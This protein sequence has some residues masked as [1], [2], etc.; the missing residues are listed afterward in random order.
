WDDPNYG[1]D[2][3]WATFYPYGTTL[4]PG[5]TREV[6]VRIINHS[7]VKRK[8]TVTPRVRRG[9]LILSDAQSITLATRGEGAVK[10]KIRAPNKPGVYVI[11][12]DVDSKGMHFRDW[13]E[14][15]IEVR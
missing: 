4:R 12:G 9:V 1:I 3:R 15:V 8:F 13:V 2:E 14:T 6:E 5:E 11:T 10:V 7:P